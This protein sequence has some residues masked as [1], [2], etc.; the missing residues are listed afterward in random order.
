MHLRP[1]R[2]PM[3]LELQGQEEA[4]PSRVLLPVARSLDCILVR[5][6]AVGELE[7]RERAELNYILIRGPWLPSIVGQGRGQGEHPGWFLRALSSRKT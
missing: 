3:L 6:E 7:A 2:G 4:G 5:W 1:E